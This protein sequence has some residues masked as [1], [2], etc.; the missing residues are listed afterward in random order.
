MKNLRFII[1]ILPFF[2]LMSCE[3]NE[4]L[5]P[6]VYSCNFP[7]IDSSAT[8][9]NADRYQAI[10]DKNRKQGIVGASVLIKDKY[11]VLGGSKW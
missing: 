11:G 8:H 4:I 2:I 6:E 5:E 9:P 3:K 7:F 1:F 10:L